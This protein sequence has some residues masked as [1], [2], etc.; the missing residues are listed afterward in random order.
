MASDNPTTAKA[1]PPVLTVSMLVSE[2]KSALEHGFRTV[3]VEGEISNWRVY[4]SGHAYCVLKDSG[5]QINAVMFASVPCDCRDRLGDGRRVKVRAQATLYPQ[6]G[7][8]Q[9]KILRIK[10]AG[11]GE[12]M[13]QYLA[14]KAKLEREGLFDSS[15]KRALPAMPRR[16]G[17]VTS[18]AGAVVHDMCRVL[19]RRFPNIEIRL[20]PVQVQGADAPR[21]IISGIAYFNSLCEDQT[22]EAW[23]PDLVIVARG[24]GSF[25]DLF[26]FNDEALVRAVA[27]SRAPVISAV[28]HETDYTLCD[29]AAD[30]RAGTPSIAAEIAV[31]EL[32]K[33][34]RRLSDMSLALAS[35]LRSRAEAT[36][37][38]IDR[39]SDALTS[40]LRH[41]LSIASQR[42]AALLP[43]PARA[44]E[45][46][47]KLAEQKVAEISLRMPKASAIAVER[48]A[49]RLAALEQSLKHLSPFAVL[50][51]GY[52]LTTDSE[53]RVIQDASQV[54]VGAHI[55][56]RLAKGTLKSVVEE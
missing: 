42:L 46:R 15:R 48:A 24:G 29:F 9:L 19:T 44:L 26:C 18:Q 5:A 8:L 16:I 31:P 27:A 39:L 17:L 3:D 14:L 4:P 11:E 55:N 45:S 34:Q 52:S 30:K 25:E 36:G 43:R 37:Q 1:M 40:S 13:A 50:D 51:R 54:S 49:S 32:A 53:G 7:D 23:K 35:A 47:A 38:H 56:T 20:F 21:T 22:P 2:I 12:L 28:G 41:R 6:R 10:I 33:I